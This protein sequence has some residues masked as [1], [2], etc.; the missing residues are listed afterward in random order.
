MVEWRVY[1]CGS[2]SSNLSLQSSYECVEGKT[3]LHVD[4]G[5]GA[6]YRRCLVEGTINRVLDSITH[7]W[8]THAHPDHV[9]DLTRL[10]VAWKYTPDY[11]PGP[12]IHLYGTRETLAA[13]EEML[14]HTGLAEMYAEIFVPHPVQSGQSLEIGDFHVQAI[15]SH[16]I[17]GSLGLRLR[18]SAGTEIAFTGDTG[19]FTDQAEFLQGLDLLIAEASFNGTKL[20]MHMSLEDVGQ[21]AAET[22]PGA[23]LLVHFY[24]EVEDQSLYEIR[25]TIGSFYKGPVFAAYDG[26]SL[27]R[28]ENDTAWKEYSLF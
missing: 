11:S 17:E 10:A 18:T 13:V 8:L 7:L 26:L 27:R 24:P 2:A 9:I 5:H 21:L 28:E 23:M 16:H 22:E 19:R 14:N 6:V 4:F 20:F 12:A 15:P 25:R 3:R 1:G